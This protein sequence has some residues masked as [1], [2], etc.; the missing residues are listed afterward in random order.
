MIS[1]GDVLEWPIELESDKEMEMD[2]E[3]E[4]WLWDQDLEQGPPQD[5]DIVWLKKI[6]AKTVGEGIQAFLAFPRVDDETDKAV[7]ESTAKAMKERL[8]QL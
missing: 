4:Q 6:V 5:N 1:G 8:A 7:T 3:Y 2:E